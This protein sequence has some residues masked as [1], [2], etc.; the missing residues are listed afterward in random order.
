MAQDESKG[1]IK[2]TVVVHP[3]MD[4]YVR[5]TW[6]ILIEQGHDATYSMALN[7]MLLIAIMEAS[8]EGGLSERTKET[9]QDFVN[10][11]KTIDR[12][13]LQEYLGQLREHFGLG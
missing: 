5:K 10:D 8:R 9:I 13:N 12:L 7:Y 2:K 11:Q 3:I 1:T 4:S 6:S